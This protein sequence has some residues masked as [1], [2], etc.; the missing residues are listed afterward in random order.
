MRPLP[1]S[2]SRLDAFTNCPKAFASTTVYKTHVEEKGEA[3]IWG[4]EVHK[5]FEDFLIDGV[6]LPKELEEHEPFLLRLLQLK[7]QLT[8]EERIALNTRAQP[9]GYFDQDVWYRGCIDVKVI[10]GSQA[11]LIDHKTGKLHKKFKQLK[12]FALHT[13]TAHPEVE[14]VRAEYYW[15]KTRTKDGET[16]TRAQVPALWAEFVPDLRQYRD[17]FLTE[18]WQPRQSGLCRGWCPVKDCEFWEPKRRRG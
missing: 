9:C 18:L 16:Y 4:Q 10:A 14:T 15:T 12:T 3:V 11:L 2:F 17:A 1:W 7:G 6:A 8:A 5:H 13:F